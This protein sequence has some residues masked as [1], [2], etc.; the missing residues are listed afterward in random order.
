MPFVTIK[1]NDMVLYE[2]SGYD[3]VVGKTPDSKDNPMLKG[4]EGLGKNLNKDKKENTESE[5]N[6]EEA[7]NGAVDEFDTESD[8]TNTENSEQEEQIEKPNEKKPITTDWFLVIVLVTAVTGIIVS[9]A[10]RVYKPTSSL[11]TAIVGFVAL[12]GFVVAMAYKLSKTSGG[13]DSFMK[14]NIT[15]NYQI[16]FW[17]MLAILMGIIGY[18]I[19]LKI[20]LKKAVMTADSLTIDTPPTTPPAE[21]TEAAE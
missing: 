2:L 1:C 16:G 4:L 6:D 5:L 17:L 7:D 18:N 19:Y 3:L 15:A 8:N 12:I 21:E 14:I 11:V 13:D 9:L 20:Q 10:S